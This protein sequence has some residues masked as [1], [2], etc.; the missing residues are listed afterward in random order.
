VTTGPL[1]ESARESSKP[2]LYKEEDG[3][4]TNHPEF[5]ANEDHHEMNPSLPGK[6]VFMYKSC[7]YHLAEISAAKLERGK[8]AHAGAESSGVETDPNFC[9][10][11]EPNL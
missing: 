11:N 3:L 5:E 6:F 1:V 9:G 7:C 10:Q 8:K 4:N 2:W